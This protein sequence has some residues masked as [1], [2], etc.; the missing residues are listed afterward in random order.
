MSDTSPNQP[1]QVTLAVGDSL[2]TLQA[3]STL[4]WQFQRR[5]RDRDLHVLSRPV[6]VICHPEAQ[7]LVLPA[8]RLLAIQSDAAHVSG[9]TVMPHRNFLTW[10]QVSSLGEQLQALLGKAGWESA[11]GTA[12][13]VAELGLYLG[14]PTTP[15]RFKATVGRWQNAQG[16]QLRLELGR[17]FRQGS[18]FAGR[19]IPTDL[20]V[21]SVEVSNPQ[22]FEELMKRVEAAREADGAAPGRVRDIVLDRY[23][24][25]LAGAEPA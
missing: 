22:W 3:R 6:A 20:H 9:F 24:E 16:D 7:A 4:D 23:L 1:P 17:R 2:A 10:Q 14:S 5:L 19:V 15:E 21:L 11:P 18:Q 13:P 8:A 12:M 25:N